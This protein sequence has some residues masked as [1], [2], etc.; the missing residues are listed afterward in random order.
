LADRGVLVGTIAPDT[1]RFVTH[2]DVDDAG[3]E[4]ALG[5]LSDAPG[6]RRA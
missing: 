6:G 5:A 4:R 1:M 3:L 2:H